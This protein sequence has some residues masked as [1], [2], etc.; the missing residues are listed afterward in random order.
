METSPVAPDLRSHESTLAFL[1]QHRRYDTMSGNNRCTSFAQC[2][3]IPEL[4]LKRDPRIQA[5]DAKYGPNTGSDTAYQLLD[6]ENLW[7][8]FGA[9][10]VRKFTKNMNHNYTIGANGRSGGYL[11]LYSSSQKVSGY[12]SHC[13]SCGQRNYKEVPDLTLHPTANKCGMCGAVGPLGRHNYEPALM[14]LDVHIGRSVG[15]DLDELEF[16]QLKELAKVVFAFD[17][18]VSQIRENFI[19]LVLTRQVKTKV[20]QV[21]REVKVLAA[22]RVGKA[23]GH[24]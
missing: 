10:T 9:P 13:V 15:E 21:P 4:H 3:K 5:L 17:Q 20:I 11:V 6:I 22:R 18:A 8:Q 19:K 1:K 7:Y 14:Q 24:G 2:V 23:V 16:Y 12:K